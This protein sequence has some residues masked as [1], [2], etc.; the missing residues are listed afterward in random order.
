MLEGVSLCERLCVHVL[1]LAAGLPCF[2]VAL[3]FL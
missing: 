1:C 2:V 3:R